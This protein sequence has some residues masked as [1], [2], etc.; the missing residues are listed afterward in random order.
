MISAALHAFHQP[1]NNTIT[2]NPQ[3]KTK[4]LRAITRAHRDSSFES[5][6]VSVIEQL[7][8]KP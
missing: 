3:T 6:R 8:T 2:F 7:H 4:S 1:V 5:L